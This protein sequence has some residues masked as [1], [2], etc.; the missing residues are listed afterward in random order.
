MLFYFGM[1]FGIY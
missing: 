1:T